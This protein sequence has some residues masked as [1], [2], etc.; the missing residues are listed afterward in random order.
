MQNTFMSMVKRDH[1]M[2][3]PSLPSLDFGCERQM[4]MKLGAGKRLFIVDNDEA[5]LL[6]LKDI[7]EDEGYEVHTFK[8]GPEILR[9]ITQH[10]L[11]HLALVDLN[12]DTMHGFELSQ[13]LKRMGDLPIVFISAEDAPDVIV[14]GLRNY[15]DDYIVKPIH[16]S[17][18]V[19]RV[20][21]IISR[22]YYHDS[23]LQPLI[24]ID[25]R[26]SVDFANSKLIVD[27]KSVMLTPTEVG[28]LHVLMRNAGR[29]VTSDTLIA[30]VWPADD[31]YEDT[32][33]VHMHRL[34]GKLELDMHNPQYIQTERGVGYRFLLP[35][36]EVL[37]SI[38]TH[39][40]R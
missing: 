37:K 38:P 3:K 24:K 40:V 36:P 17:E 6:I 4:G 35:N 11:P 22:I 7:F 19:L 5:L 18:L 10:G 27:G 26:V 15:A 32:L 8:D 2:Q 29:V 13:K 21:R 34:R 31:V 20:Q 25:E 9:Y 1:N 23:L 33:R 39:S 12:L 16:L 14:D 30:R 28:L